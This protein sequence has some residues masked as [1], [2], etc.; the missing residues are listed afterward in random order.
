MSYRNTGTG[1]DWAG[2]T[3]LNV[4]LVA[5]RALF[6][7]SAIPTLG[8]TL[9]TGSRNGFVNQW[10]VKENLNLLSQEQFQ[11]QILNYFA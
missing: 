1:Y 4:L 3:K 7:S 5:D 8:A 10:R 9:P 2:Q 6:I 11:R